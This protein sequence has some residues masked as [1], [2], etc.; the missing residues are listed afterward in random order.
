MRAEP[1]PEARK[2][3]FKLWVDFGPEIGEKKSSAQITKHYDVRRP[4][5]PAGGRRRELP[6]APDRQVHVRGPGPGRA[7]R[8]R[9]RSCAGRPVARDPE[10]RAALRR[11]AR[12]SLARACFFYGRDHFQDFL[13]VDIR[14]GS[15]SKGTFPALTDGRLR[16][17]VDFLWL[18]FGVERR[19]WS[20]RPFGLHGD[21]RFFSAKAIG[22]F[23]SEILVSSFP[24]RR[25]SRRDGSPGGQGRV[26]AG[27]LFWSGNAGSQRRKAALPRTMAAH[28]AAADA[29]RRSL[30]RR[31][32]GLGAPR[33]TTFA[34]NA[35][36]VDRAGATCCA[37]PTSS[38]GLE[39]EAAFIADLETGVCN[40][41]VSRMRDCS[42]S[43]IWRKSSPGRWI[44]AALAAMNSTDRDQVEQR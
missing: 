44:P 24:D 42:P 40:D 13:K 28:A 43:G 35:S 4:A 12:D 21:C 3:A 30:N 20:Q 5:G 9:A 14:V 26:V 19:S 39:I 36:P 33:Q 23:M 10:R 27:I 17:R 25:R 8:G 16:F 37:R 29:T 34:G 32:C 22:K 38:N 1:F 41:D 18:G 2:P 6:A 31:S 7:G 11:A 15:A